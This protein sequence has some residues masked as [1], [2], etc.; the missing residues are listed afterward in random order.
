[1][2]RYSLTEYLVHSGHKF[3]I[4]NFIEFLKEHGRIIAAKRTIIEWK[5]LVDWFEKES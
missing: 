2:E 5:Q 3:Q 1:M 4:A